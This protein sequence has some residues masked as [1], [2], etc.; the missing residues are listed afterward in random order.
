MDKVVVMVV[1]VVL[2]VEAVVANPKVVGSLIQ[3]VLE[4]VSKIADHRVK[5]KNKI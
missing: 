5:H 1:V 4:V 2:V 3:M